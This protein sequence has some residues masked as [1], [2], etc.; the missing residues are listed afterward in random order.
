MS[1][2][3]P[4]SSDITG[5]ALCSKRIIGREA[6]RPIN[7]SLKRGMPTSAVI[8]IPKITQKLDFRSHA[9]RIIFE[10]NTKSMKISLRNASVSPT[11][12]NRHLVSEKFLLMKRE[13][14]LPKAPRHFTRSHRS[15]PLHVPRSAH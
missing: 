8:G 14:L 6:R 12:K 3:L 1:I 10:L 7:R 5:N 2:Q 13:N 4:I 9:I 11:F 15:E